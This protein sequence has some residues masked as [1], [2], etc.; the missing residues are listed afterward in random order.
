[1][2]RRGIESSTRPGAT[3]GVNR[4]YIA[5]QLARANRGELSATDPPGD[6]GARFELRLPLQ[7]PPAPE[8]TWVSG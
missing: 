3:G 4:L 7:P 2:A 6:R 5:R 8:G 1:M